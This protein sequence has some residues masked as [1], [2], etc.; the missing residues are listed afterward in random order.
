[1]REPNETWKWHGGGYGSSRWIPMRATTNSFGQ[2]KI[3]NAA[4]P[5]LISG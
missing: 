3:A 1:M 5:V 2:L 4:D